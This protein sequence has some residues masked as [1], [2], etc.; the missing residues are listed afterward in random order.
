MNQTNAA[1]RREFKRRTR[2]QST[3][4]H[5]QTMKSQKKQKKTWYVWK[6]LI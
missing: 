1:T 4:R 6:P 3:Q 5:T 2:R